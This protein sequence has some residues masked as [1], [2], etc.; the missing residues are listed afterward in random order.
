MYRTGD[1]VR[2]RADGQLLFVGRADDQVKIRGFRI[3]LGEVESA[4]SRQ[5]GVG[6][7]VAVVSENGP[8]S[9]RLVGYVTGNVDPTVTRT[10]VARVLAE[11]MVPA[12]VIVLE[13]LPLTVNGKIDRRALPAPDFNALAGQAPPRDRRE[14]ILCRVF[15]EVLGI[16]HVGIHDDFFTLGG[17][18]LMVTRL[19]G[20][21]RSAL[22]L[23]IPVHAVFEAPTV[24]L[25]AERLSDAAPARPQLRPRRR[26]GEA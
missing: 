22:S 19:V 12:V 20:R 26:E 21:A 2:W 8:G 11:F 18:S 14:E 7:A 13:S 23:E 17:D 4:L 3:E 25:L 24:A 6:Q 10:S 16:E 1:L 9:G 15:A 5:P